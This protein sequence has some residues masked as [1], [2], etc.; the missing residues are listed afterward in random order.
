MKSRILLFS[1]V[2]VL[3]SNSAILSQTTIPGG[4]VSGTWT[5]AGSPYL[6]EGEITIP[7]FATLLIN[8]GVE[9]NFQ[10]H[11]K[12]N[13]NGWLFA[14]GTAS[15][16]VTFTASDTGEGWHGIRFI[17]AP[18]SSHLYYCILQYGTTGSSPDNQGGAIYCSSSSPS[19]S[20]CTI[21]GNSAYKGGGIYCTSSSPTISNCTISGNS[22]YGYGGGI[23]C[24]DS[25]PII[26]AC[27]ISD[28]SAAYGAGIHCNDSSPIISNC[29]IIDN[30]AA[31]NGGGIN[32]NNSSPVISNCAINRNSAENNCGGGIFCQTNSHPMIENCSIISNSAGNQ[33][34]GIYSSVCSLTGLNNIIWFNTAS[35]YSQIRFV[36]CIFSYTFSNVQDGGTGYGNINSDPLFVIGPDGDYYLSQ[37]AAGQAQQSPCVDAG[38]PSSPMIEGTSRTDGVQDSDFI[39]M[40]F[41]YTHTLSLSLLNP[42]GGEYI[43]GNSDCTIYWS[44]FDS[45]SQVE[46]LELYYST[47]GGSSYPNF[48]SNSINSSDSTYCWLVPGLN[49]STARIEVQAYDNG[50]SLLTE[51]ASNAN[52]TIDS[53]PPQ[54]FSLI[55]PINGAWAPAQPFFDWETAVDTLS[56]ISYYEL[57]IDNQFVIETS[58]DTTYTYPPSPLTANWHT[59]KVMAFDMA[60]NNI[61]TTTWSFRV[62]DAGP[63]AFNLTTPEN[64][65][66]TNDPT[67]E[68]E[69]SASSD[70]GSGF[71]GYKLFV[72]TA[73]Y[74]Y[75]Y[76]IPGTQTSFT[77]PNSIE[78]GFYTWYVRSYDN[79]NNWTQ[80]NQTWNLTID[81]N[82]PSAFNLISPEDNYISYLSDIE[83]WWYNSND[84]GSGIKK[85]Q[86]V[87]NDSVWVD[88]IAVLPDTMHYWYF[89]LPNGNYTWE[90][91]AV[92]YANNI[93][94]SNQTWDLTIAGG[95]AAFS[96]T[97]P[98]DTSWTGDNTPEFLWE[99]PDS[100]AGSI[101]EYFELR[102]WNEA[103][104]TT[105]I[106]NIFDNYYELPDSL[107][108]NN[109]IND[110]QVIAF[111]ASG[112][113]RYSDEIWSFNVDIVGPESFSLVSPDSLEGVPYPTPMFIW[114]TT[115][116]AGIGF[117][118]YQLWIDD[119]L[120]VDNLS[121]TLTTPSIPMDEGYADW[122]V[123]A[124]DEFG[125]ETV[126][127]QIW[128]VIIDWTPPEPFDL[129]SPA[130]GDTV[131]TLLP[132]FS[133]YPAYDWGTG[134]NRYE[135]W[136]D[137]IVAIDSIPP[138]D[139]T[140]YIEETMQPGL[141]SWFVK[142]YDSAGG[143]TFSNQIWEL[144]T[145]ITIPAQPENLS[146]EIEETDIILAWDPVTTD[147]LGN[148]LDIDFYNVYRADYAYFIPDSSNWIAAIE[149]TF[150]V[151]ENALINDNFFYA[152][153][154]EVSPQSFEQDFELGNTGVFITMIWIP[155]GSF[156]QGAYAGELG[157]YSYDYPQH[158]VTLDY[159]FW[160]GMYEVTQ[161]QWETVTGSNPAH[162]YGVG[163]NYPVYYISWNMIHDD[164]LS[165]LN[166]QTAGEPWRLPSESEWEYA[167]RAGAETRYYWGDDLNYTVIDDYAWYNL[168]SGSQ[169]HEV[170]TKLPNAWGLYDM[171][172]NIWECVEDYWHDNYTGAPTNGDPWLSP[173]SGY[174]ISRGGSW[175]AGASYCRSAGRLGNIPSSTYDHR[176]FRIVLSP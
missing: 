113:Q 75:Q 61:S 158:L 150:Y 100:S 108:L 55:S 80:S 68:F 131:Y 171:S 165:E 25:I 1:L 81:S 17:D 9:V 13:V 168:N 90:I 107:A 141:H 29:I 10:G 60:G 139:T 32:C 169:T 40:G 30:L 35:S 26:N 8:P 86:L 74:V 69:W 64:N 87:L 73:G 143:A 11:Y 20:N 59:W 138:S 136:I 72:D 37:T 115:Y 144:T 44:L 12:F 51:D 161:S 52:I 101:A 31:T 132:Q 46:H 122:Y 151:D 28:N 45:L 157:A 96:L 120:N 71:W 109:G 128:T 82:P 4:N 77:L 147:I 38:Y 65:T 39:D 152:V 154:S 19:I 57:W 174:R 79:V 92:D 114:E 49:I 7:N 148:P 153:T 93:R 126:S 63:T 173:T 163:D 62:D 172:G 83:F 129:A 119:T 102:T 85:Y 95:P 16:S 70:N 104:D 53:A 146:V 3:A 135:L 50:D 88:S 36:G 22:T 117:S 121:D 175:S 94:T 99:E 106:E 133:W 91:N 130:D 162:S 156:M 125:N 97:S 127:N 42:N 78:D 6:I 134:I 54:L 14:E 33:G 140:V 142:A 58:A 124:I 166:S 21:S 111:D 110:W 123:K 170:G 47:D 149:D 105:S 43:A 89:G 18:D 103:S 116:D 137:G 48:I 155:P 27:T 56:G 167:C 84:W 41:H 176:G 24:D 159:G 67:P 66:I 76:E 5:A 145:L 112:N 160:L 118:H 15:D 23:Y 34:G 164:F 98:P 2:V